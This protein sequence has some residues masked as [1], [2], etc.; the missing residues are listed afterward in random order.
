MFAKSAVA[1]AILT[2]FVAAQS[3]SNATIV[4]DSVDLSTRASWCSGQLNSCSYLCGDTNENDC[5]PETLTID[6]RCAS[7]DTAPG[8]QYYKST[9]PYFIC[10]RIYDNCISANENV[11]AAQDRCIATK[12]ANCGDEFPEPEDYELPSETTSSTASQTPEPTSTEE[13]SD[14]A[15]ASETAATSTGAAPTMAAEFGS[16]VLAVGVAAAFGLLL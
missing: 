15:E 14:S 13:D 6:C 8:L 2:S 7:N 11:K 10:R 1:I 9:L 16:G 3:G 5:I 4:P 12:D